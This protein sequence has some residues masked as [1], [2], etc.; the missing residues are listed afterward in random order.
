M[1]GRVG[2][3]GQLVLNYLFSILGPFWSPMCLLGCDIRS[4]GLWIGL[5][6]GTV[7]FGYGKVSLPPT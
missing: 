2:F 7:D 5:N 1:P 6:L 3:L 4:R